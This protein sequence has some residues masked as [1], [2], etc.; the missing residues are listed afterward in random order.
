MYATHLQ[1]IG[2]VHG[3]EPVGREVLMHLANWLFDNYLK[4][5]LVR[6]IP[7]L[8]LAL[9]SPWNYHALN[10]CDLV[11][12]IFFTILNCCSHTMLEAIM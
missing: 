11:V 2:N 5:P 3:D 6:K 7:P 12:M 4:D 1:F 9:C 10:P 8:Q